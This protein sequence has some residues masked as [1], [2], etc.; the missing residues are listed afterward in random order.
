MTTSQKMQKQKPKKMAKN[1]IKVIDPNRLFLLE[2]RRI[3]RR[4]SSMLKKRYTTKPYP[5][6]LLSL[7]NY[8]WY[9]T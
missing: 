6:F 9:Y 4:T 7:Y 1:I 5:L 3:E 2:K 8:C